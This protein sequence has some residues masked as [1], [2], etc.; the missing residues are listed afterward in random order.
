MELVFFLIERVEN[1]VIIGEDL[2]NK[3]GFVLVTF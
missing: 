3:G 1:R 2:L